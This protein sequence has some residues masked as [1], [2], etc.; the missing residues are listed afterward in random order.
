MTQA[1]TADDVVRG[2][3]HYEHALHLLT[4]ISVRLVEGTDL[5]RITLDCTCAIN[6]PAKWLPPEF[7]GQGSR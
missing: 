4:V 1:R 3:A 6:V 2:H 5:A 7:N